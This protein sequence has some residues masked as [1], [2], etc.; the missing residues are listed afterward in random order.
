MFIVIVAAV[1]AAAA[2]G[3]GPTAARVYHDWKIDTYEYKAAT[4][5]WKVMDV[6]AKF[7]INAIH[8]SLLRTGKVLIVAGSGNNAKNFQSKRFRTLLWDP[9]TN[10]FKLVKTPRDFFCGGQAFLPDGT[11][12]IAGGTTR[13]EVL[14]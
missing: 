6:P 14:A 4:G 10:T 1:G 7:R 13:Y 11:L 3:I 9:A 5:R 12:L 2:V 8:V